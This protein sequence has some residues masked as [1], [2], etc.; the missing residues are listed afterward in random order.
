VNR[1]A[2]LSG[3]IALTLV[4][5]TAAC[6]NDGGGG[7]STNQPPAKA[8]V[9]DITVTPRDDVK[10]GGQ[11]VWPLSDIPANF[12]YYQLDG[13]LADNADIIEALMPQIYLVD[14]AG[15][16]IWNKDYLAEEPKLETSPK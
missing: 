4:G 1:R 15:N 14:A 12:N 7:G 6:S 11:L 8:G 5:G 13:T 10:K 9:N 2:L 3:V 16:A